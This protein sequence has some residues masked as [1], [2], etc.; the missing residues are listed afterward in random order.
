LREERS[1]IDT[2]FS[3]KRNKRE[4]KTLTKALAKGRTKRHTSNGP[5]LTKPNHN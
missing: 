3:K 4:G 5:V 1:V 2:Y